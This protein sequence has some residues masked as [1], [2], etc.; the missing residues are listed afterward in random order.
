MLK[1]R[2]Y[3][4]VPSGCAFHKLLF[5]AV[6]SFASVGFFSRTISRASSLRAISMSDSFGGAGGAA[7]ASACACSAGRPAGAPLRLGEGFGSVSRVRT[8]L[9]GSAGA[10]A[11]GGAE[12]TRRGSSTRGAGGET[13]AGAGFAASCGCGVTAGGAA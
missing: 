3:S 12:A 1:V 8:G 10:V 6:T 2:R 4:S 11:A 9:R 7:G 5:G 13:G